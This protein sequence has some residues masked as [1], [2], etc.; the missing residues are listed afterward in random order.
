[1]SESLKENICRRL[2]KLRREMEVRELDA[3][4]VTRRENYIFLSGFTGTS[5]QLLITQE[6][7]ILLTD[8][9]Y[10]EQAKEQ[11]PFYEVIRC[12]GSMSDPLVGLTTEKGIRKLGFEETHVTWM[13][14]GVYREKLPV[15]ELVALNGLLEELR[16]CKDEDEIALIAKAVAIADQAFEHV[17]SYIK[18]GVAEIEI[19]AEL[20]Y[21]MKKQGATGPS[22]ETIVA[23]GKRSALPHGVASEKKLMLGDAVTLDFGCIY[24]NYCSDMTRTVFLGNPGEELKKVYDIVLDAQLKAL[25]AAHQGMTGREIDSVA[26][27]IIADAGYENHFGHGLGH[28]VGLEIHEEPRLSPS[29]GRVMQKGMAVT[30]EPGI[31]LSGIGGVRIEDLIIIHDKQP[32]V[33]TSST[34][35]LIVL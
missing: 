21:F 2:Q 6:E 27:E 11:A 14:Y 20:E 17:L 30:V 9:R 7:A 28:G 1:M 25:Q 3:V 24:K 19:A 23:S 31:Y 4:L 22:F 15:D 12:F 16:F 10:E 26:R 5:A 18:P 29:G 35:E 8:F 33:L 13:S 34:K 32:R